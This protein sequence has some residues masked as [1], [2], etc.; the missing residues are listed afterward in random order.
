VLFRSQHCAQLLPSAAA[1]VTQFSANSQHCARLLPSAA[2]LVTLFSA[3]SQHCARLLPSA[4]TLVT[5]FSANTV[6]SAL[7]C[8]STQQSTSH[9]LRHAQSAV[10]QACLYCNNVRP[11]NTASISLPPHACYIPRPSR[12]RH[13][14]TGT[15]VFPVRRLSPASII[16]PIHSPAVTMLTASLTKPNHTACSKCYRRAVNDYE[17]RSCS[18]VPD[19][20][21]QGHI[22]CLH[23]NENA[24]NST[25]FPPGTAR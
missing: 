20:I 15:G 7:C 23:L 19:K 2:A 17:N 5:L 1:L 16:A 8:K 9:H 3:N 14:D 12:L 11:D 10:L 24:H 6:K 22:P 21:T 25:Q 13:S 18:K 4:A